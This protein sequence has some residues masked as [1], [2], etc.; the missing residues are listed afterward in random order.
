MSIAATSC[1]PRTSWPLAITVS[2]HPPGVNQRL[3]W[4]ARRRL[5][6]P[7]VDAIGWQAKT[8]G[9]EKPLERAR[10]VVTFTHR[11]RRYMGD[12]DNLYGRA[13]PLVDALKGILIVD[14]SPTHLELDVR[15]ELGKER[16]VRLQVWPARQEPAT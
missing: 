15:Q 7:F 12:V 1:S 14:D 3:H 13:K 8:F 5:C 10:V 6:R 4:Q 9:L 16:L 11:S 2:G